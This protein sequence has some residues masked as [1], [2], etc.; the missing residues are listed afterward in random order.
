MDS[1]TEQISPVRAT[2][3]RDFEKTNELVQLL[4]GELRRLAASYL[5]RESSGHTL[6]PTALVNEAYLRLLQ[7]TNSQWKD[8]NHFFSIAAQT[9]RRVLVDHARRSHAAKRGGPVQ[10][11][12]LDQAIVYSREKAGE[13]LLLD[14]LMERLSE[15]DPQQARVVEL[16]VFGGL[17]VEEAAKVLGVSTPTIKRDWSMA[18]A[19]LARE[20]DRQRPA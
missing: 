15:A 16:R 20:M 17:T 18:K 4:Y 19:W 2:G 13:L 1:K 14:E 7:Q 8:R 3:S 12:S 6:Q 9:M 11:L 10:K 5:R